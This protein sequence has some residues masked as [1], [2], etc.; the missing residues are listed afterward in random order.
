MSPQTN[1]KV[2]QYITNII[3]NILHIA[4][5]ISTLTQITTTSTS[6]YDINEVTSIGKES[7]ES[8]EDNY[9]VLAPHSS[10]IIT[11]STSTVRVCPKG[12]YN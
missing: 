10:Q 9:L 4:A 12:R 5:T 6:S 7:F 2:I 8:Q 3:L 11:T 1:I